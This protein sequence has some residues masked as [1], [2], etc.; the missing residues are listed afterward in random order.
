MTIRSA[1]SNQT[2]SAELETRLAVD[3]LGNIY[4]LGAFSNAVFKF[5]PEGRYVTRFGS[6]GDEPGQLRAPDAIAVDGQGRVYV[7][8]FKGIQV[9]G[10]DGRFIG[11]IKVDGPASGMVFNDK[12]ELFVVARTHVT[13]YIV[14][15]PD[16]K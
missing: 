1:I 9:F 14:G 11:L 4:A 10:E 16:R 2:E 7:G 13:K 15:K 3:G 5:S 6:A 12:N 8:D